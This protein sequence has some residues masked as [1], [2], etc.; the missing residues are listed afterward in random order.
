M[1]QK[2]A[3]AEELKLAPFAGALSVDAVS[4]LPPCSPGDFAAAESGDV[5]ISLR[6][7]MQAIPEVDLDSGTE[8]MPESDSDP[9][10]TDAALDQMISDVIM[11]VSVY[12]Q[13][14]II[15]D[16]SRKYSA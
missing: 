9:E 1:F 8:T 10:D 16:V 4:A 5:Q 11:N 13:N 12:S 3:E 6:T 14:Y 15:Y 2:T 7:T